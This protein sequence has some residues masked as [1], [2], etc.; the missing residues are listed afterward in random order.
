MNPSHS[1]KRDSDP[2]SSRGD[3]ASLLEREV[4]RPFA[5]VDKCCRRRRTSF[6]RSGIG[7]V[8][9]VKMFSSEEGGRKRRVRVHRRD[10]TAGMR[11]EASSTRRPPFPFDFLR[12]FNPLFSASR[13]NLFGLLAFGYKLVSPSRSLAGSL[14]SPL[15]SPSSAQPTS[16]HLLLR[17][18]FPTSLSHTSTSTQTHHDQIVSLFLYSLLLLRPKRR[19]SSHPVPSSLRTS[20]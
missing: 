2:S 15:P 16:L 8:H 18:S 13:I 9:S 10:R 17:Y 12:A 6:G 14:T 19:V 5:R 3:S 1:K 20:L 11:H 4:G 7:W